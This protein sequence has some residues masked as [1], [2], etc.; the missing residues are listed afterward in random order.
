MLFSDGGYEKSH[1][2]NLTRWA[3]RDGVLSDWLI[4]WTLGRV[5]GGVSSLSYKGLL[6]ASV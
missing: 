6:G 5:R 2:L 4:S 3:N 1:V